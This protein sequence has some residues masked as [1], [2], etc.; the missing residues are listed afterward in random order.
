MY[1]VRQINLRNLCRDDHGTVAITTAVMLAALMV[2]AGMAIDYGRFMNS[3]TSA[4]ADL[5]AAALAALSASSDA[6]ASNIVQA[7]LGA[8]DYLWGAVNTIRSINGNTLTVQASGT[9]SVATPFLSFAGVASLQAPVV[10]A[11]AIYEQPVSVTLTSTGSYGWS[12][13]T[14]NVHTIN[15]GVDSIVGSAVYTPTDLQALNGRGTG[16]TIITP[17]SGNINLGTYQSVYLELIVT[18]YSTGIKYTNRSD[19]SSTAIHLLVNNVWLT[20]GQIYTISAIMPCGQSVSLA[21]EDSPRQNEWNLQDMFLPLS[22]T[23]GLSSGAGP[24]HL[25]Q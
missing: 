19:D 18:D 17:S 20:A 2:F 9:V 21:W 12:A 4:R 6:D 15:N 25:I 3:R 14:M 16:T 1:R 11:A 22:T 5:D 10:S 24:K 23:C 8:N 13:K 7:S